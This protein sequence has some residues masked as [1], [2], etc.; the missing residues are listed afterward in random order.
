MP[1]I[2]I[3]E[4]VQDDQAAGLFSV[5]GWVVTRPLQKQLHSTK[6]VRQCYDT[7]L[8]QSDVKDCGEEWSNMS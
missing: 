2:C 1:T 8:V 7:C 6:S 3:A 4:D 5:H